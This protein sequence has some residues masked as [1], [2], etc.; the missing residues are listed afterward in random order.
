MCLPSL[1]TRG[2]CLGK[3]SHWGLEDELC[4]QVQTFGKRS[5]KVSAWP[6]QLLLFSS[7]NVSISHQVGRTEVAAYLWDKDEAVDRRCT[8]EDASRGKAKQQV[9]PSTE[10]TVN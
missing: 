9:V 4:K 6:T 1:G 7:K 2:T 3:Q 8:H 5:R 10:E